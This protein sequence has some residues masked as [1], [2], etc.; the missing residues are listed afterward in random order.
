MWLVLRSR[1]AWKGSVAYELV[2]A[3]RTKGATHVQT[4]SLRVTC[5]TAKLKCSQVDQV[6]PSVERQIEL[7]QSCVVVTPSLKL[8]IRSETTWG[9]RTE[10]L[11]ELRER[12][13]RQVRPRGHGLARGWD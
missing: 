2:L 13:A 4:H 12:A 6:K 8:E 11:E 1:A 7:H 3:Q 10:A 5:E 9:L